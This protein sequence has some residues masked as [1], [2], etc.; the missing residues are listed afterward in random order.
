MHDLIVGALQEN[1]SVIK[2]H[3]EQMVTIFEGIIR[4]G[5]EAGE[6]EVENPAEVARAVK[7]AFIPFLHPILIEHCVRHG[8]DTEAAVREQIRFIQKALGKSGYAR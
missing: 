6:F 2:A 1:W 3:T 7:S 4:E 5:A 8:E